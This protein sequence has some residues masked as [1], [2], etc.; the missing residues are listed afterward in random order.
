MWNAKLRTAAEVLVADLQK[1]CS[2]GLPSVRQ[3][4]AYFVYLCLTL[5][6]SPVQV[7][8]SSGTSFDRKVGA[9]PLD[10]AAVTRVYLKITATD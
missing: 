4:V 5:R 6:A 10:A 2:I 3:D 8:L 9:E 7:L 1:G